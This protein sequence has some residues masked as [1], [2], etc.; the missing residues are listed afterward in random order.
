MS[1]QNSNISED[2]IKKNKKSVNKQNDAY[3]F[4]D[5]TAKP[6]PRPLIIQKSQSVSDKNE[7]SESK[8]ETSNLAKQLQPISCEPKNDFI[9]SIFLIACPIIKVFQ[10][11]GKYIS[12]KLNRLFL[13]SR[14]RSNIYFLLIHSRSW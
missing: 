1:L 8:S 6:T 12:T 3:S 11:K 13:L 9:R 14:R 4:S 5:S 10:Q 2:K 7:L